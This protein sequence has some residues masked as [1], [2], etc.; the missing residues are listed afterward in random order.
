MP[1]SGTEASTLR[2]IGS[3]MARLWAPF[4][5]TRRRGCCARVAGIARQTSAGI[6]AERKNFK[7]DLLH[8][9]LNI[10]RVH[11]LGWDSVFPL[12]QN[13]MAHTHA[14]SRNVH[15]RGRVPKSNCRFLDFA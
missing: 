3:M 14:L 13:R 5:A 8:H 12:S 10:T 7:D 9:A 15:C 11:G 4:S 6:A 1:P 2:V